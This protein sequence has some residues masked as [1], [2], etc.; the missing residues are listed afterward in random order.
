MH[1]QLSCSQALSNSHAPIVRQGE[2]INVDKQCW[3]KKTNL[4]KVE[5]RR[6]IKG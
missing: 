6:L 1:N 4:K 2:D 5:R 3:S